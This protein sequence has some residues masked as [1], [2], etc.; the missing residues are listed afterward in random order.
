VSTEEKVREDRFRDLG[1]HV[2]RWTWRDLDAPAAL[3]TRLRTRLPT[4]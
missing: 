1:L 3:Q 2:V 4:R